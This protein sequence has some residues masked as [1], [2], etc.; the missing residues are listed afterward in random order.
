[1]RPTLGGPSLKSTQLFTTGE[2]NLE[3]DVTLAIS[4]TLSGLLPDE[5]FRIS[6]DQT[7][8]EDVYTY[9]VKRFASR[10]AFNEDKHPRLVVKYDDSIQDDSQN[11]TMDESGSIFLYNYVQNRRANLISGSSP[12]TGLDSL[13]LKLSTE[14]SGGTYELAFSASQHMN[15][16]VSVTGV[17]SASVFIPSSDAV[18]QAKLAVSG[19][20]KL[21]PIWGSLD[22]T[23]AFT[24]A[25]AIYVGG[26]VRGGG[27]L[28]P[29]KLVVTV[30]NVKETYATDEEAS[31]R[32]NVFDHTS[33]LIAAVK[34][35]VELPG[36]VIRDVHWQVRDVVTN[37]VEI[38]FDT[39]HN[40]TRASS[41]TSGM[42]FK[43]DAS[44]LTPGRTYVVDVMVV[45]GNDRQLH[46]AASPVWRVND[47]E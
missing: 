33:P 25:S 15:G 8:E 1:M 30:H 2:E 39:V 14:V 43:L 17:Y 9:F 13:M 11:L 26:P 12:V 47:L 28:E 7:H 22:G 5:G 19:A 41:D 4:A 21:T 38:P 37:V 29:Q 20:V 10:T 16:I 32:I 3:L 36:L 18:I 35:P 23:V 34:V 27:S 31:L 46:K 24:T 40:S 6:L 44:N 42:Y 45:T